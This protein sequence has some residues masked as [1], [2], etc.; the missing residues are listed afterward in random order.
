ME[1]RSDILT[2]EEIGALLSASERIANVCE[3]TII[4]VPG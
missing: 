4:A 1:V 2:I 3:A